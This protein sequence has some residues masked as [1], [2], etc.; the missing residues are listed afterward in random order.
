VIAPV[1]VRT[2]MVGVAAL[3]LAMVMPVAGLT[4]GGVLAVGGWLVSHKR[5]AL[6]LYGLPVA[7]AGLVAILGATISLGMGVQAV[8]HGPLVKHPIVQCDRSHACP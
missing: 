4:V 8:Q 3:A 6:A 5:H 7:A 1:A 2:V